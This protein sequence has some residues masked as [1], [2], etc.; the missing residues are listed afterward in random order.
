M[1]NPVLQTTYVS[2]V[3]QFVTGVFGLYGLTHEVASEHNALKT[4]L[5]IEMVVQ[6]IEFGFYVWFIKHF[7]LST[8]APTR[9]KDWI[10]STPLMLI[11]AMIYFHY[12]KARQ[13]KR[14][15]THVIN[16]FLGRHHDTIKI[17]V[18]A[19]FAM[20]AFGYAGE[21]GWLQMRDSVVLGFVSMAVA[22]YTMWSR[23][24][25]KSEMGKKLFLFIGIVWS[26][27]GI[28]FMLPMAAKNIAYN[29]LDVVAKNFFGAFL[30]YKVIQASSLHRRLGQLTFFASPSVSPS[31][32]FLSSFASSSC[33]LFDHVINV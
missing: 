23:L 10:V 28:A 14:D 32:S 5:G 1:T 18:V 27:Y 16:E 11:S 13:E 25:S 15:T 19:N 20:I 26:L 29:G 6:A 17:V 8:M 9:Y 7:N 12:E 30:A 21:M 33:H 22:F 24:A 4:S 3:A 2:L 31:L